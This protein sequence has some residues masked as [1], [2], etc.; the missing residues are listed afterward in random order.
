MPVLQGDFGP[1]FKYRDFTVAELL[2]TGFP[3]SLNLVTRSQ[4][5]LA[6]W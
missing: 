4:P 1:S 5:Q 6:I 2:M 3:P